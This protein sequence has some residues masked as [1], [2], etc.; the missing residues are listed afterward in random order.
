MHNASP[1]ESTLVDSILQRSLPDV[2][3]AVVGDYSL[4]V[5]L[6]SLDGGAQVLFCRL[7]PLF[8]FEELASFLSIALV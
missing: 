3:P 2:M 1:A 8:S 4:W 6:K 5:W 7:A